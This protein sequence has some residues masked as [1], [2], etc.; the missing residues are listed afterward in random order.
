MIQDIENNNPPPLKKPLLFHSSAPTSVSFTCWL[1]T[2][3]SLFLFCFWVAPSSAQGLLLEGVR[4]SRGYQGSNPSWWRARQAPY[5]FSVT[6]KGGPISA[7]N[8]SDHSSL[9][10]GRSQGMWLSTKWCKAGTSGQQL[11]PASPSGTSFQRSMNTTQAKT[12]VLE[13]HLI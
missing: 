10:G 1:P 3:L 7:L 12:H 2:I 6:G 11:A 9:H 8:S 13:N 5:S 4:D